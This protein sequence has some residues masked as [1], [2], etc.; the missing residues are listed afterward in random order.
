MSFTTVVLGVCVVLLF[1][2]AV[3]SLY[4]IVRGPAVVDRAAGNEALVATL[5]SVLGLYTAYTRTSS[6][7]VLLVSLSLI[8]FLGSLSVARF[9]AAGDDALMPGSIPPILEGDEL[10]ARDERGRNA[11]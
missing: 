11:K 9:G 5:V 4:V 3:M 8:G 7:L 2:A 6:T 10:R 1:S